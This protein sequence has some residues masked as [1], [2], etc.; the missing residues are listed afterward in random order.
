MKCFVS[1]F[2]YINN[3]NKGHCY[4]KLLHFSC[5]EKLL[6]KNFIFILPL[7]EEKRTEI[8]KSIVVLQTKDEFILLRTRSRALL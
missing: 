8:L 2:F 3:E 1:I 4:C 7:L 5:V 6:F